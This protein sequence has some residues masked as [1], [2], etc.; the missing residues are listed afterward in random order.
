MWLYCWWCFGKCLVVIVLLLVGEQLVILLLY[1]WWVGRGLC[2]L[3]VYSAGGWAVGDT[4]GG[5]VVTGGW[6]GLLVGET[7]SG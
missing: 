7:A 3:G 1:G 5:W 4:A 6:I 2:W